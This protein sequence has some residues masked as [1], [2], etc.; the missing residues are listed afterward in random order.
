M[1][2]AKIDGVSTGIRVLPW[3]VLVV[4][5][6]DNRDRGWLT[7][8]SVKNGLVPRRPARSDTFRRVSRGK[9]LRRRR[10]RAV[11][12]PTPT[13]A[14]RRR[15]WRGGEDLERLGGRGWTARGGP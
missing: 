6:H 11:G 15:S 9:A 14:E 2:C 1:T 10:E 7:V 4:G 13:D 5:G 3:V 8:E 12:S